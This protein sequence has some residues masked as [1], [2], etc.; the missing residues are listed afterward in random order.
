MNDEVYIKVKLSDIE[1][2]QAIVRE[3]REEI[4]KERQSLKKTLNERDKHRPVVDNQ[5]ADNR[6]YSVGYDAKPFSSLIR[7][8]FALFSGGVIGSIIGTVI[9]KFLTQLL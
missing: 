3:L 6:R 5:T 7:D 4:S 1:A 8:F 9:V 2:A